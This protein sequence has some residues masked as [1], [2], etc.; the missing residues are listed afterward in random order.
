MIGLTEN[1]KNV[2]GVGEKTAKKFERLG[3]NTVWDLIYHFPHRYEDYSKIL[4]INKLRTGPITVKGR[5]E[6]A[7]N[8]K[9]RKGLSITEA[10][11]S[12]NTGTIKAVWF[13][14]P[15]LKTSLPKGKEV[16]ISG[17]LELSYNQ[18]SV[19]NPNV[20]FAT[21]FTKNTA[22]IVPI[23]PETKGLSSKQIRKAMAKVLPAIKKVPELL[24]EEIIK[25]NQLMPIGEALKQIHF[26]D[27]NSNL[28]LARNRLAYEEVF[29]LVLSSLIIKGEIKEE[30]APKIKFNEKHARE[31]VG[32]LKFDLTDSQKKAAWQI[33][34][35][36]DSNKV[37]NR[38]LEGDVGSGKTVVAA[39]AAMMSAKNGFQTAL[40]APTSVL[41]SQHYKTLKDLFGKDINVGILLGGTK[42]KDRDELLP[43]LRSRKIDVV[44]GT[45]SLLENDVVFNNLGLVVIDEQHRFGV[46][47]RQKI[48]SKAKKMPHLLTMS[49]TPIPRSLALTVYG[50]LDLSVINE[51]P[52]NRKSVVTSVATNKQRPEVYR[53]IDEHIELGNQVF[54]VCPLISESD[55]LG[56][57]SVEEEARTLKTGVFKHRKIATLH[58]KLKSAEKTQIIQDFANKKIDILVSTTVVEVGVDIPNA[59]IMLIEGAER[60]GLAA[61]HQ[62]RGR[63]GRG[64][65][66]AYCY[67]IASSDYQARQ[68]LGLLE[69][70]SS[71]FILAQK[72]LELR[73]RAKFMGGCN[74][75]SWIFESLILRMQNY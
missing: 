62:L 36:I 14:Q 75:G 2:N 4:P 54:V 53:H 61:L 38:L 1:I 7:V 57:K 55:K 12:D 68:R 42:K 13:N 35:D 25:K 67:V 64:D 49:A 29:Y 37:M 24:P 22:R 16:Y 6:T 21:S 27:D 43:A 41:A 20:E 51:M 30:Q 50:D 19:V 8:K 10:F 15:F 46:N 59:T 44:V 32:Q 70:Y 3:V 60:F 5:I 31:F 33:L 17:V 52:K 65:K 39:F 28:E 11:I 23:Y 34:Q 45:H 73:G 48:K 40:M 26:P 66:Q 74:T 63:V 18:F 56:V 47:Q 58:G 69:K 9:S 71:G 72:D